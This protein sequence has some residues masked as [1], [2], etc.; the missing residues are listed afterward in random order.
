MTALCALVHR[1]P[2]FRGSLLKYK[3]ARRMLS[4][5][6][7]SLLWGKGSKSAITA[8]GL[9]CSLFLCSSSLPASPACL[10][11]CM[12]CYKT[13]VLHAQMPLPVANIAE[14]SYVEPVLVC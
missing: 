7:W 4:L 5:V 12:L 6:L 2:P 11:E 14:V 10:H 13:H 1:L 8:L 3:L 9:W